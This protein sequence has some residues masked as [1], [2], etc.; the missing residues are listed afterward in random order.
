MK[1]CN[2]GN[3]VVTGP[4]GTYPK[5]F[6]PTIE[7]YNGQELT[8]DWNS[9]AYC[10]PLSGINNQTGQSC[11]TPK[12]GGGYRYGNV[13]EYVECDLDAIMPLAIITVILLSKIISI[14]KR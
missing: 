8:I 3:S 11:I 14:W 12:P 13:I 6:E 4:S 10:G 2:L 1:G 9:P 5:P 7:L